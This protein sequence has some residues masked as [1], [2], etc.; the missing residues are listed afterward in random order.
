L[1]NI[2]VKTIVSSNVKDVFASFDVKLF[3]ALAPPLTKVEVL[4]F[5]GCKVGDKVIL[6]VTPA[7]MKTSKWES[8]ISEY[9]NNEDEIFFVDVGKIL[10]WPLRQWEHKHIIRKI[11]E[12]TSEI[13]DD[14]YYKTSNGLLDVLLYLPLKLQFLYRKPIYQQFFGH[15]K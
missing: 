6:D 10:P 3:K 9:Q 13:I 11:D 15:I 4:R 14:V 7:L 12:T 8:L 1:K 2:K 5:D